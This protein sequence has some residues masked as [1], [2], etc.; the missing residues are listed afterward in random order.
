MAFSFYKQQDQKDC[1]PTCLR[2]VSK[3]YGRNYSIQKLRTL[4]QINRG[5]VSLLDISEAAEK[6]GFRTLGVK[7]T[8]SSLKQVELPCILHWQ[9]NHFVVLYKIKKNIFYIADP[10]RGLINYQEH[11]LVKHW[12]STKEML[13]GI[14]LV[15]SP[16]VLFYN[17]EEEKKE[18]L[19][20]GAILHYFYAYKKLLIQLI[21]GLSIGTLLSLITPFLT[22]SIVDIGINTNNLNF[23]YIILIAQIM[24]FLGSMS[25]NFL[26][27]WILLHVS[28]R[29][30]ISILTD[31]LIK[32]LKLPISYF[33]TKTTGDIMQRIS[34]QQKI[35][36][37]LTGTTLN[38][39]FSIINLIVFN[40]IL[41]YYNFTI[42]MVSAIS[43]TF[44]II[45]I[46]VFLKRRRELNH[47]HFEYSSSNQSAIIE[48]VDGIQEIK[49][50][51]CEQQKRWGWEYIQAKL[52][53]LKVKN[54]ALDQSQQAGSMFINQFKNIL[55]TFLSVKAVIE[56]DITLGG[57]MAIQ[58]IVG[59]INNPIEQ[60][61]GFIQ[62]YQDAKISLERLSEVH[63]IKDEEPYNKYLIN[64]LPEN[65]SIQFN[66]LTFRYPGAGNEP[67]LENINIHIPQG[68][69]TAIVGMSGSGK[70]TIL[71]LLLRFFEPEKGEIRVGGTK[72]NQFSFKEWRS[73][74]GTVMQDGFIFSDTLEANI[75]V[76]DEFSDIDK[77]IN[78]IK[79]A[80]I[81]DF[82][83]EL[84]FGLQ[85]KI[86]TSGNGISQGQKQRIFIARA[87]YKNPQYL[88]FDEATNAL[89]SNN[90]RVIM[91]NLQQF[92][93]GKT[94]V[95]IAHRLSTVSAADNI[96]LIN[97]GK[98]IEQGTHQ[99]LTNLRGEYY[100]L[101]RNQLELGEEIETI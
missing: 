54:L 26:R 24:L 69:T 34:D 4:C 90:E 42:F 59:Q 22:Q 15:L 28:T 16:T 23:V 85:T 63:N 88:F 11:E 47:K 17:Q 40:V 60:M 61:L 36:S 92:F 38:T 35:E 89:D 58:Y 94:V 46:T 8:M 91:D 3:Y 33:E 1:G 71:K 51:N 86:G 29:I 100:T 50:N 76:G 2:M 84:P 39:L 14:S 20:W 73:Q 99:E 87:V 79:I 64:E 7:L 45:W 19:D 66:N 83:Q 25:I 52:F 96:I 43:I 57:M 65:K 95:I 5:G 44:Y 53:K 97:K 101:V 56:G 81:N 6:I 70:T 49:L 18:K 75:A 62:S 74:C 80:N 67:I 21:I 48:L 37:F 9:Q 72:L 10:S 82:I 55:I 27:S 77:L 13:N 12:F 31:F 93:T 30:N 78:A 41:L 98:I 32:L 68:K